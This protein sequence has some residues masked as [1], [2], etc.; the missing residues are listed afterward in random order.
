MR[1]VTSSTSASLSSV[2]AVRAELSIEIVTSAIFLAGRALVPEKMTSSMVEA[3][4]D[5]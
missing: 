2:G 4:M 5:L 1:R 3:R